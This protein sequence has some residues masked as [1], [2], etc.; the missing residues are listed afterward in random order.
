[1]VTRRPVSRSGYLG[2]LIARSYAA[3]RALFSSTVM[4][5]R[6]RFRGTPLN[7]CVSAYLS[8]RLPVLN[9]LARLPMVGKSRER[10]AVC[11]L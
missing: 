3:S 4:L 10:G 11:V 7:K 5:I 1:M 6:R 9:S 8:V 2:F